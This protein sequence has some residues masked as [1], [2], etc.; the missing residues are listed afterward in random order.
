MIYV[1]YQS[2]AMCFKCLRPQEDV[3]VD[4]FW[5]IVPF[6]LNVY[7]CVSAALIA[8]NVLYDMRMSSH[9]GSWPNQTNSMSSTWATQQISKVTSCI[10]SIAA[11]HSCMKQ[12][13]VLAF[14][15][16]Y[17]MLFLQSICEACICRLQAPFSQPSAQF[18]FFNCAMR[19]L[20]NPRWRR[21]HSRNS[22]F[23]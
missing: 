3:D 11:K 17:V 19:N 23:C 1:I 22:T 6:V 21:S 10:P 14:L 7:L 15:L 5:C 2:F 4:V 12:S 9:H 20:S 16:W 18:V 8:S 13:P